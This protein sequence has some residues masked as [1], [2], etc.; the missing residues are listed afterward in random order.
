MYRFL[1]RTLDIS[2]ALSGIIITSPLLVVSIILVW[3]GDRKMPFYFA[4]RIGRNRKAF[5][6]IKI[7][8]MVINAQASGVDSTANHD[9]RIT[10]IGRVI[11]RFKLDE[12]AQFWNVLIGNMSIVGPRPNLQRDT[13][14]YTARENTLLSI[15][16]GITDFASIVF[17]DEGK[18]LSD[19]TDPD[20]AYHQLI[21]PWKSELGILYVEK[22][23]IRIDLKIIILTIIS[24]FSRHYA[25]IK[26]SSLVQSCGAR[27]ELVTLVLR[28]SPLTPVAPPGQ[29]KIVTSREIGRD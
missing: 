15:K 8:S 24:L 6:M 27:K 1:K 20:I 11:R 19:Q 9:P 14:L 13:D 29:D 25:L 22:A 12:L 2:G 17:S 16:P 5:T 4:P 18:I 10:P 3:A 7:R 21:R 28:E 23:N 26:I